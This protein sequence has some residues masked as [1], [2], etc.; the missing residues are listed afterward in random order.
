VAVKQIPVLADGVYTF[1]AMR[2]SLR[3]LVPYDGV[4]RHVFFLN[5]FKARLTELWYPFVVEQIDISGA[6]LPCLHTLL[7][8]QQRNPHPFKLIPLLDFIRPS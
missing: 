5:A 2:F 7:G 8:S 3:E 4:H 6:I 1:A